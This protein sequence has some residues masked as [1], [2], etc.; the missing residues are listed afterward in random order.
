[1][2]IEKH[3]SQC[4]LM[5]LIVRQGAFVVSSRRVPKLSKAYLTTRQGLFKKALVVFI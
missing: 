5:Y 4:A 1:M 2:Y 3:L